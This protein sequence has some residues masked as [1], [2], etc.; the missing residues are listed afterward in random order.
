MMVTDTPR[1]IPANVNQGIVDQVLSIQTPI[2]IGTPKPAA[3]SMPSDTYFKLFPPPEF[4]N[5]QA[6]IYLPF[7]DAFLDRVLDC[8]LKF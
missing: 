5:Y 7:F 2:P 6:L 8:R 3:I 1:I 4:V